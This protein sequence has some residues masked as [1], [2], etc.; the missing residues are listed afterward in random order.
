M[1]SV[2]EPPTAPPP[3]PLLPEKYEGIFGDT[4]RARARIRRLRILDRVVASL[5][6]FGGIVIVLAVFG[7]F[8]FVVR[9]A[10]PLVFSP[11]VTGA[12]T[13]ENATASG[14]PLAVGEDEYRETGWVLASGGLIRLID[15][16]RQSV[17]ADVPLEN[18]GEATLVCGARAASRDVVAAGTSDGRVLVAGIGYSSI[19]DQGKRVAQK[20]EVEWQMELEVDDDGRPIE[21]VA[22]ACDDERVTVAAAAE[23]FLAVAERRIDGERVRLAEAMDVLSGRRP[24]A[25]TIDERHENLVVGFDDG[26]VARAEL[27][28]VDATV[29]ERVVAGQAPVTAVGYVFG[30]TTLLVGDEHGHVSG[31]HGVRTSGTGPRTLSRVR[32][33]DP[34]PAPIT[35]FAPSR[36]NKSFLVVDRKGNIRLEH[37][38]TE[39]TLVDVGTVE[40]GGPVSLA[41]RFDGIDVVDD[42]GRLRRF[43]V[44]APHPETSLRALFLP[45]LYENYDRPEFVWQTSGGSDDNEPKFSLIPLIFGSL[46]GVLY[47][48]LFSAPLAIFAAMF[49]SQFAKRRIRGFIKPAV[50]LMGALPSVVVGFLAGLWLSPIIDRNLQGFF[51]VVVFVPLGLGLAVLAFRLMS[52]HQRQRFAMGH[53]LMF[54]MPFLLAA[55]L[56]ATLT[57]DPIEAILFDGSLRD[58]LI[59]EWGVA[60]DRQNCIVVGIA[61]G[62]AVMP[63]IFTVSEDAMSN[64]PKSL[65]AA[66]DALGASRWQT[67]WRLVLPAASPGIFAAVML[68]FG[69]AIGETMIVVMATGNTPILDVSP[70]NGMR[71]ISAAIATEIPEAAI[72]STLYR[73]LFLA[74]G[75]L[76]I[77]AFLANTAAEVIAERLRRRYARW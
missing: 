53:E 7:I 4:P 39:Q 16:Q 60:Y 27:D 48:M 30:S 6:T 56:G 50:E 66:S 74:G 29:K 18:L 32:A 61:L 52:N 2:A 3:P 13:I 36:R 25:L 38:T 69:R 72:G 10:L 23:G 22:I 20:I 8:F 33:F 15:F 59:S 49:T 51:N 63:I 65:R 73:V 55:C 41:P 54:T 77:F 45:M 71:T 40:G 76:F 67:A 62:F 70:F 26:T 57:A 17:R 58:W 43:D 19:Y 24:T 46:K 1:V 34:M 75:L 5:I 68:G 44:E 31:W 9:E 11:G 12:G 35:A 47:A 37:T 14:R 64:V 28:R 21:L 42:R